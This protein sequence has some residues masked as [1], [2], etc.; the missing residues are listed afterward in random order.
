MDY[1]V[2]SKVWQGVNQ[3]SSKFIKERTS[4]SYKFLSIH[5]DVVGSRTATGHLG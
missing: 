3:D 1:Q 5:E 4:R 2:K